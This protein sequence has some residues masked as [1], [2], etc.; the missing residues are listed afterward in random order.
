ME[1]IFNDPKALATH[2]LAEFLAHL[3]GVAI[4]KELEQ[5]K[6]VGKEATRC[7]GQPKEKAPKCGKNA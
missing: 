5:E 4:F 2:N 1:W 7:R 3:I 6:P